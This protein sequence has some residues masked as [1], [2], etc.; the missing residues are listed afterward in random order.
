MISST[1]GGFM[2]ARL[3]L[4]AS[5]KALNLTG[6]NLTNVGTDGY[7]RQRLDQVSLNV[8]GYGRYASSFATNI[9]N[10]VLVKGVSQLRDPFLDLRFRNEMAHVGEQEVTLSALN[11]LKN[12]LDEVNK[13]GDTAMGKG[14]IA[15]QIKE[16]FSKLH[17]LSGD[18]S[19]KSKATIVKSACHI[20]TTL[21]NSYSTRID[22]VQQNM[23]HDLQQV[24]IPRI[25]EILKNIQDLNQEIKNSEMIGDGALELKDQRNLLIDEL[26]N[27]MKIDV[28]Y[29][30]VQVSDY[31]YVDKLHIALVGQDGKQYEIIN[32]NQR[33]EFEVAK[34]DGKWN[35]S[36]GTLSPLN[37]GLEGTLDSARSLLKA[38]TALYEN[39]LDVFN[40]AKNEYET[41]SNNVKDLQNK[42]TLAQNTYDTAKKDYEKAKKE[43][44]DAAKNPATDKAQLETLAEKRAEAQQKVSDASKELNAINKQH[45]AA[46]KGLQ[47]YETAYQNAIKNL[48]NPENPPVTGV[49]GQPVQGGG[50]AKKK[51]EQAQK[52]FDAAL[53]A[54][55][56]AE[57][58]EASIASANGLLVD[59]ILKG[60]LNML[61]SAGD[62]D[63]PPNTIHGIGHFRGMLDDLANQFATEMNKA[64]NPP[65]QNFD[66]P[67]DL[68]TST[69]GGRITA[70]NITLAQ[71]WINGTYGI[72]NSARPDAPPTANDNI[73]HFVTIGSTKQDYFAE[74]NVMNGIKNNAANAKS[75]HGM[76]DGDTIEIDG[77]TYTFNSRSDGTAGNTFKDFDTLKK[78]ADRNG[79]TLT[80]SAATPGTIDKATVKAQDLK[81]TIKVNGKPVDS[82][83]DVDI[84]KMKYGDTI[85]I[86]GDTFTFK[87]KA[88]GTNGEFKDV[89]TLKKAADTKN[90]TLDGNNQTGKL[91][92]VT[93][94]AGETVVH[95]AP[96]KAASIN[97]MKDGETI[98]INGKTFTFQTNADGADGANFGSMDAL[99]KAA[100]QHGIEV[101]GTPLNG[102]AGGEILSATVT[103]QEKTFHGTFEEAYHDI[104]LSLGIDIA[105]ATQ[106]RDSFVNLAGSIAEQRESVT[107]VNLD[108]EAM[109]IMRYKQSYNASARLLTALDENL[110]TLINR[111]GVAGR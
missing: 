82:L 10:G 80:E 104:E 71:G 102:G 93:A 25:N 50:L 30:P 84:S 14:G 13:Q 5:Q 91:T 94:K 111:T 62:Y 67:H 106:Q 34:K 48:D 21:F 1:F 43:Y 55:R 19:D 42:Q 61:N 40:N 7:T 60:S 18:A 90:I 35:L 6:H 83:A 78:A 79:I 56:Q 46:K 72:T 15:A 51:M 2:T 108:E 73:L 98:E 99:Q 26:S 57:K 89:D 53:D 39:R 22:E 100:A 85:E 47:K 52:D 24:D 31:T 65:D 96:N 3:G 97:G 63:N 23:E 16:V 9:G 20:L 38:A 105:A 68:F 101:H 11:D 36:L 103:N 92:T 28:R 69:D 29:E 64:N 58:A 33:R 45:E 12:I 44:A 54:L 110:D 75:I 4:S 76:K 32:D 74:L 88:D 87:D 17:D 109:N 66:P 37:A 41:N 107:G 81:D 49:N 77:K 86:D 27:Y 95:T 70:K 59:G 8:S